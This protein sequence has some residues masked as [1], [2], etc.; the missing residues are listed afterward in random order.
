MQ[1]TMQTREELLNEPRIKEVLAKACKRAGIVRATLL[2]R[3]MTDRVVKA[4]HAVWGRLRLCGYSY[5]QIG[6]IFGRE[7]STI[8]RGCTC[9]GSLSC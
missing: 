9:D 8:W 4:R 1:R 7:P 5:A 2:G 3:D 6:T